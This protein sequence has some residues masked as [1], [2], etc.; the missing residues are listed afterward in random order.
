[1]RTRTTGRFEKFPA[2]R[3]KEKTHF[4][5]AIQRCFVTS[6]K[7]AVKTD[8]NCNSFDFEREFFQII[9]PNR[10]R[11]AC[12]LTVTACCLA[13]VVLTPF[14][15]DYFRRPAHVA[16]THP[17]VLYNVTTNDRGCGLRGEREQIEIV[18]SGK[19]PGRSTSRNARKSMRAAG[20][21]ATTDLTRC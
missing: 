21:Q 19:A 15:R 12:V 11:T 7:H 9:F 2:R 18:M 17:S 13:R 4:S 3:R 8:S 1:M 20:G 6:E 5:N 16:D 10:R 14:P